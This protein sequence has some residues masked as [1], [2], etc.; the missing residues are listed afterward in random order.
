L[1][2]Y[3]LLVGGLRGAARLGFE[4][5]YWGDAVTQ[6]LIDRW[7]EAAPPR[8]CA[9]LVPTLHA[10]QVYV[11]DTLLTTN[12][13]LTI[14]ASPQSGCPYLIVYNRKPYL[15]EVES[16]LADT[17]QIPLAE[18]AVDNVWLSRVY[19]RPWSVHDD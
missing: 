7:A 10:A 17:M 16:I 9:V 1:S 5:T 4:V 11:Y 13:E 3:N 2:Y 18:E 6:R 19:A 8:S 12:K 15:T 14:R